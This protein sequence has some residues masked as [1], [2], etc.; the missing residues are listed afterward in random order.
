MGVFEFH[1]PDIGEGVAEAELVGW[2]VAVGAAVRADE[3][4][5]EVM[6]DK[7]TVELPSPV[8]GEVTW[9]GASPGDRVAVGAPFI[10]FEV[11]GSGAHVTETTAA[12]DKAQSPDSHSPLVGDSQRRD[13]GESKETAISVSELPRVGPP[14]S[15]VLASPAIRQRALD[16]G[17]DLR[18]VGGTGPGG[19]ITHDDLQR[20]KEVRSSAPIAVV[21]TNDESVIEIPVIGL[22]RAIAERM[23]LAKTRIPHITYVEEVDVTEIEELRSS[24]NLRYSNS[25]VK[26]TFLPFL[27]SAIT[28]AVAEQPEFNARFNDD[29]GIVQQFSSVHIGIA[30]QT[31]KGLMVP[32]LRH[33]RSRDIW[34]CAEE[35]KRLSDSASRGEL[36]REDLSGSTIT[37]TSLGALGGIVTT[38]IINYPEVAIVGVNKMQIRPVWNGATFDPRTMMNLSSG[39]DHRII[40]G[41]NAAVFIGRIK[42]LLERPAL[43]FIDGA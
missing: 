5:A 16:C 35:I 38:P 43:M 6:T 39:F 25:R 30:T 15:R 10:R 42:E 4:I 41:W 36:Q 24:L 19:R 8:D 32:V 7:A 31:A 37:I 27:I 12:P 13:K 23:T 18:L 33:T 17:V 28:R 20:I 40:D 29:T 3:P 26:L 34:N 22:R 11:E 21:S 9:L 14:D 1:L 2:F